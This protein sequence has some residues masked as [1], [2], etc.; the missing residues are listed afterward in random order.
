MKIAAAMGA[1][2][3]VLSQTLGKQEDGLRF[4]AD[5]LLRDAERDDVPT[6]LRAAST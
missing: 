5:A 6:T 2:V 3:T 4:G 1:E